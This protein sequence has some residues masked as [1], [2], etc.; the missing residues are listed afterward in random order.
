MKKIIILIAVLQ[1]SLAP[2]AM[3]SNEIGASDRIDLPEFHGSL[4]DPEVIIVERSDGYTV[5]YYKGK[6]YVVR[7]K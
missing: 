5:I 2:I 4:D 7:T 6:Y 1:L 3:F